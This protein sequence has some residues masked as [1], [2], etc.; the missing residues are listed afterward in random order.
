V[1]NL[2]SVTDPLGKTTDY[3]YD[4][5]DRQISVKLPD[6]DGS[7]SLDRPETTYQYDAVGNRMSLTDPVDNTT[8]WAYDDLHLLVSETTSFR[9]RAATPTTRWAS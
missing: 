1:T 7:G 3:T 8:T 9:R 5:L 4:S 6:P 2:L